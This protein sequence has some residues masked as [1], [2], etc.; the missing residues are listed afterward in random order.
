MVAKDKIRIYDLAR[1]TVPDHIVDT[2]IQKKS[3]QKLLK[4]F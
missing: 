3:R 1:E 2:K 4:G